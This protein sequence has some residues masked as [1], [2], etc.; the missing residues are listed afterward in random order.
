MIKNQLDFIT[1]NFY[2]YLTQL[3]VS[4]KTHKNYRSDLNHFS[5]WVILKIRSLGSYIADM[6]EAI[7]F[8]SRGVAEEYRNYL[9]QNRIPQKTVNRRLSTLRHFSRF[10]VVSQFMDA[11]FMEGIENQK[12]APTKDNSVNPVMGEFRA[13]LEANK[14]SKNTIKNYLSDIRHFLQWLE[15]NQKI[16]GS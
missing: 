2:N 8:L 6:T 1:K 10:L 7:P 15:I 14:I 3:R 16:L 11:D 9:T 13:H 5:G 12:S 4:P